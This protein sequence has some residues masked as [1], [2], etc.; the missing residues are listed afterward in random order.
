MMLD[1]LPVSRFEPATDET[2]RP[3]HDFLEKFSNTV[4]PVDH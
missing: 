2:Y 1:R 4:R 3:V